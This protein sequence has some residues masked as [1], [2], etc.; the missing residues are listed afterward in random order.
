MGI[1]RNDSL[2]KVNMSQLLHKNKQVQDPFMSKY[3]TMKGTTVVAPQDK[4]C[5]DELKSQIAWFNQNS[6]GPIAPCD[7]KFTVGDFTR[8]DDQANVGAHKQFKQRSGS[9]I[10]YQSNSRFSTGIK[11][12]FLGQ[13]SAN[14]QEDVS[15][16]CS[17]SLWMTLQKDKINYER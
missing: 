10:T 9:V 14:E 11:L 3:K 17:K 6:G 13:V 2:S 15:R 8:L 4:M 1:V 16:N 12:A 7:S 5:Y